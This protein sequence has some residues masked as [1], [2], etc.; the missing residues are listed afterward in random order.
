M[1][2]TIHRI[3]AK[4]LFP[5]NT[6]DVGVVLSLNVK[7][8]DSANCIVLT[9]LSEALCSVAKNQALCVQ[10]QGSIIGSDHV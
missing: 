3:A 7:T 10:A 1:R 9:R 8:S 2:D 6:G 5:Q 4:N